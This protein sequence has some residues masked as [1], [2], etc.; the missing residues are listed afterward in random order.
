MK[1]QILSAVE[2]LVDI[3]QDFQ[4]DTQDPGYLGFVNVGLDLWVGEESKA[5]WTYIVNHPDL[6]GPIMDRLGLVIEGRLDI[7]ETVFTLKK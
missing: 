4:F 1:H 5:A 7:D 2:Q 3:S 6:F